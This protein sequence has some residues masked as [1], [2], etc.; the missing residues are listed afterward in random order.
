[1][2]CK[3]INAQITILR[4][5]GF[6]IAKETPDRHQVALRLSGVNMDCDGKKFAP[7][8]KRQLFCSACSDA[9]IGSSRDFMTTV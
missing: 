3:I 2:V 4:D 9:K 1:V 6:D 8:A 7:S 5:A